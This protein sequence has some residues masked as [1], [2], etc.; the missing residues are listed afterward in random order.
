MVAA[1]IV[2]AA[3]ASERLGADSDSGPNPKAV[4]K[5]GRFHHP[6][7]ITFRVTADPRQHWKLR[8]AYH[9][10]RP[11]A[12]GTS[13]ERG[14]VDGSGRLGHDA[15]RFEDDRTTCHGQANVRGKRGTIR[16]TVSIAK[17]RRRH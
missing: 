11:H 7:R 2:P 17:D 13:T 5:G 10:K 3:V 6:K 12:N 1:G 4:V 9:C 14:S 16:L 8:Y 15:L